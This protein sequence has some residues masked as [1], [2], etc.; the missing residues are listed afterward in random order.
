MGTVIN[1]YCTF[2]FIQTKSRYLYIFISLTPWKDISNAGK[3]SKLA[4]SDRNNN[5]SRPDWLKEVSL[6]CFKKSVMLYAIYST[7][8]N[9]LQNTV[10][11]TEHLRWLLLYFMRVIKILNEP[12]G[13]LKSY[14]SSW[15]KQLMSNIV[16]NK[17][18]ILKPASVLGN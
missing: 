18:R 9:I 8:Q 16:S 10:S 11:L 4:V 3:V 7:L 15:R 2:A 5:Y 1:F 13:F 12:K 14:T 17:F 6:T